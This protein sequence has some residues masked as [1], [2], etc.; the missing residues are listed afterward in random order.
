MALQ[1]EKVQKCFKICF[2]ICSHTIQVLNWRSIQFCRKKSWRQFITRTELIFQII[3]KLTAEMKPSEKFV[4]I[5]KI[6]SQ[7]VSVNPANIYG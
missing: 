6:V 4:Q 1:W 3:K 7:L 5:W 2:E